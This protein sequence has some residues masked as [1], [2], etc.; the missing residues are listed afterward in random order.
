MPKRIGIDE[1]QP[2]M[3]VEHLDRSWLETPCLR[4]KITITSPEQIAQLKASGVRTL[5]VK[6]ETADIPASP[7]A[8]PLSTNDPV[9]TAPEAPQ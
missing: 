6:S 9:L 7:E 2:G 5:V 4:H 3:Q 8:A 1:L